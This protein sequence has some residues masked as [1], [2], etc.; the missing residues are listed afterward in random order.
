MS[1][2]R[3]KPC[4]PC[5]L[6]IDFL[7]TITFRLDMMEKYDDK[8]I[9]NFADTVVLAGKTKGHLCPQFMASSSSSST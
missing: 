2:S 6:V 5:H 4:L 3:K 9:I 7:C 8:R 1:I